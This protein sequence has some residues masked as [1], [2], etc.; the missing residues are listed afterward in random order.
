MWHR[1][2]ANY[3]Q[4]R[5]S[6]GRVLFC[7][8]LGCILLCVIGLGAISHELQAQRFTFRRIG[9]EQGL[10]QCT[11]LAMLQDRYGFMW[12]CTQDGLNRY[13]GY[14]F[15]AYKHNA[16][17]SA[18]LSSSMAI[19]IFEDRSGT[20]WVGTYN[21]LNRLNRATGKF[22]RFYPDS[23]RIPQKCSI[24]G[25]SE[26]P[27]G[28]LVVATSNGL[29]QF[30]TAQEYLREFTSTDSSAAVFRG[31]VCHRI[32]DNTG[33]YVFRVERRLYEYRPE[34]NSFA[35]LAYTP[36][37][38]DPRRAMLMPIFVDKQ[39]GYW[40]I[41]EAR[42]NPSLLGLYRFIPAAATSTSSGTIPSGGNNIARDVWR[43]FQPSEMNIQ[44]M[45]DMVGRIFQDSQ[46]RIW[47]QTLSG[48]NLFDPVHNTFRLYQ[49]N[50]ADPLSLG[51]NR[52]VSMYEDRSGLL[53]VA[54]NGSGVNI[55]LPQKF[56]L[57]RLSDAPSLQRRGR[58]HF[59]KGI[60]EDRDGALWVA[61]YDHGLR[62]FDRSSG[63]FTEYK[64]INSVVKGGIASLL[65]LHADKEGLIW[66]GGSFN[67]LGCFNP[68][69]KTFRYFGS[70]GSVPP[71]DDAI[72]INYMRF[73]T[74]DAHGFLWLAT[75]RNGLQVFS[76]RQKRYVANFL[77][78]H[79]VSSVFVSR[80]LS[81]SSS[82]TVYA[83]T[84]GA[85]V[86][87]FSPMAN[88]FD[89]SGLPRFTIK[90]FRHNPK[91]ST[92]LSAHNTVKYF[93]ED[94][95]GYI[96]IGM[97]GGGLNRFDP[98]T[99]TF[100]RF[101]ER[102]GLPNNVVY[103]I[104][105]DS[106]NNLWLS[107]N[108]G[109]S[110]FNPEN[111]TFR[112][113]DVSDGLQAN[114]FNSN[115]FARLRT[116]ELLFG[117]IGGI[118]IF[119]PDSVRDNTNPPPV[120]LTE[121]LINDKPKQFDKPV[122]DLRELTLRYDENTLSFT[123][124]GLDY[125]NSAKNRYM[126][127]LEGVTNVI[128][129]DWVQSGTGRTVRYAALPPG[130]Y[131]FRVKACNNDGIWNEQGTALKINLV[132]PFWREAWFYAIC[133]VAGAGGGVI[134][135]RAVVRRRFMQRI[136]RLEHERALERARLG[137]ELAIE[138]ERG[139]IAQDIHDEVGPGITKIL[140]LSGY[141]DTVVQNGAEHE[142]THDGGLLVAP[143]RNPLSQAAQEVIDS[144]N[145]IIWMTNPKNDTL[146][147]LMAYI[148]EYAAEYLKQ[149]SITCRFD[150]PD[151]VPS[152]HLYGTLRRNIFLTV[153]EALNNTVKHARASET[154]IS[155]T[156][157]DNNNSLEARSPNHLTAEY[158]FQL[159]ISDDGKGVSA[160]SAPSRF[161]NGLD[162][163][164]RRMEECNCGF[165]VETGDGHGTAITLDILIFPTP[166]LDLE[167]A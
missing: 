19:S 63:T 30:D 38:V 29:F 58:F 154:I 95:K 159:C 142:S 148:R 54:S 46:N 82:S 165:S 85:G 132:P 116:G 163:M 68:A 131:I 25:I 149:A 32:V 105:P 64:D 121:I 92:T 117:G 9:T 21:G 24:W 81:S 52:I 42:A 136:E 6:V 161:G 37:N 129:K 144:M 150:I 44:S 112:N 14:T 15:K 71:T 156:F 135:V 80:S 79:D 20:M 18:S 106:R 50:P 87:M 130:E 22:S 76:K 97:D 157:D 140:L 75:D 62:K 113:Y 34:T 98:R 10:S 33:R 12:L 115:S 160:S 66:F 86:Y 48:L 93:Y 111:H 147:N 138:R 40:S 119:H 141:A 89:S 139:R 60:V 120:M 124:A 83:G 96:W 72:W 53:W 73:L 110:K 43:R 88:S 166:Y 41:S 145:D 118:N 45:M 108:K 162:N 3:P 94:S 91:D 107:T 125:T 133:F 103:G 90:H 69:T 143:P 49:H 57:Y 114:E 11:V 127:K 13:D 151:T 27:D 128:D 164:R 126:Y 47:V 56:L 31:K 36:R 4:C 99:E 5:R 101:S 153:K 102:N 152:V 26:I 1:P 39:G 84:D 167:Q 155:L 28:R 78:N 70:K 104:L 8:L 123:F 122:E 65:C 74:E 55:L 67:H 137:R 134:L 2:F 7:R 35:L 16:E 77:G 100:V 59:L 17:D 109:L 146:D 61:E 158:R 23:L 51:A